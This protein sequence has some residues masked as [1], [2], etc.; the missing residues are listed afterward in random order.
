MRLYI[1]EHISEDDYN[2]FKYGNPE[3][4]ETILLERYSEL[5][6]TLSE[7][8][9][10][11][12]KCLALLI[13][14]DR[15]CV[16]V[17]VKKD[18]G[19]AHQ[20]VG[21]FT[22]QNGDMVSFTGSLNMTASAF[23]SNL[24]TIECTCSWRGDDSYGK[25][26]DSVFHYERMWSGIN[27][28]VILYEART[29]CQQI[30]KE[31]PNI[32][33]SELLEEE[34]RLS[35]QFLSRNIPSGKY[36]QGPHFPNGHSPFD[37]QEEAYK[38]WVNNGKQGIFAMA[39]GTGKTI[40]SLNCVLH[41]YHDSGKYQVLVLVPTIALVDQWKDEVE[42]FG[43]TDIIEVSSANPQWRARLTQL[44]NNIRLYKKDCSFFIVST[45]D[46][47]CNRDFQQLVNQLPED[48]IVIADEAHNI[49]S[50]TVRAAF[51][52]IRA[53]RR[54]ALSATPSRIYDD[55][56]TAEIE[57]LFNDKHPYI[58][59]FSMEKAMA[60]GRL[61][62]Y[63]YYPII[64]SLDEEEM[65]SYVDISK[66]LM[67]LYD[68]TGR[69]KDEEKAKRLMQERK[70]ILHKANGKQMAL[71]SIIRDIGEESLKYCFVYV[72]EG[73]SDKDNETSSAEDS[74]K[75][76]QD[77]LFA[78]KEVYPNVRCNTY[79]G[80]KSKKE[81][82]S[83]LSGFAEGKIDVLLA[84]KCLDEGVDIPRT[85]YGI[86]ASSTGNPRQFIQRRGRLLRKH[87][88]KSIAYIYDMIVVPSS[89]I[90]GVE[91]EYFE[92]EAKLVRQE[93]A[94]VAYFAQLSSNYYQDVKPALQEIVDYYHLNLAELI[95]SVTQ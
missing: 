92:I 17:V 1:N 29:F 56:G 60:C 13:Q 43:F 42:S 34:E 14:Q 5:K 52:T 57:S 61:M 66:R 27:D 50:P 15:I 86:F 74:T 59:N 45:Y 3:G 25:V 46:S 68:A 4:L 55:E 83:I 88:D 62:H 49:G 16:R 77:M 72:P 40:T 7:R 44:K 10:H 21:I 63:N 85:Q 95:L 81:R 39:T 30:V 28:D 2:L 41:E 54:I 47:Y 87:D 65:D 22:D 24:E 94:R 84:M 75:I 89:V 9:E 19:L 79:I 48:L 82:R 11:F 91:P 18:G 35:K 51:K 58:V 37:Y 76:I 90:E 73:I 93:L 80:E 69:C 64:V 23:L 78:I 38:S 26:Q 53:K 70:R 6:K 31:Y 32:K 33:T 8:N 67:R 71:K 20:K 12:F 36:N